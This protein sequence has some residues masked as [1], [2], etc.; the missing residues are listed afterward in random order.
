MKKKSTILLFILFTT[1][2]CVSQ[3][4]HETL[5]IY[6]NLDQ[7]LNRENKSKYSMLSY[8]N[9]DNQNLNA[10]VLNDIELASRFKLFQKESFFINNI[11]IGTNIRGFFTS[12]Y[13]TSKVFTGGNITLSINRK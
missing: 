4:F 13:S 8:T 1:L 10:N 2:N 12:N 6:N 9:F 11:E 3:L 7:V 5:N